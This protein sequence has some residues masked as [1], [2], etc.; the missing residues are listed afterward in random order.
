MLLQVIHAHLLLYGGYFLGIL[1][2][3]TITL[4]FLAH[5]ATGGLIRTLHLHYFSFLMY[6]QNVS[7]NSV[8]K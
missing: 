3:N 1:G 4:W 6:Q 2:P 8:T 7:H 5:G